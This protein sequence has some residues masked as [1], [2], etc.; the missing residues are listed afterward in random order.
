[1]KEDEGMTSTKFAEKWLQ[2]HGLFDKDSDYGGMVGAAVLDVWKLI[3]SQGHSGFSAQILF[4]C[5]HEINKEYSS[6]D[7]PPT[8]PI[9]IEYWKGPHGQKMISDTGSSNIFEKGE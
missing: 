2:S 3:A 5:L 1:M 7:W 9:W 4:D 8:S 6:S